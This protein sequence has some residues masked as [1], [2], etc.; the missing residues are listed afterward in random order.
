MFKFGDRSDRVSLFDFL[1]RWFFLRVDERSTESRR[2]SKFR[3]VGATSPLNM[4]LVLQSVRECLDNSDWATRKAAADTLSVLASHSSHLVTDGA[5]S[6]IAALEACR[7]DKVKPARDS[8]M[9]ALQAAAM[10][11]TYRK[12]RRYI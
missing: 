3:L 9:E 5:A 1:H 10:E 4:P 8:I 7:F 2:I 11:E 12:R 6:I